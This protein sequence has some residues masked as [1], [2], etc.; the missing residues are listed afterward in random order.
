[1]NILIY[2]YDI[3]GI[4]ALSRVINEIS[5]LHNVFVFSRCIGQK[6]FEN[7]GIYSR[8]IEKVENIKE[9]LKIENIKI[10]LTATSHNDYMDKKL[11]NMSKELNIK[12]IVLL[13][14]WLNL[15]VRFNK[16]PLE[17]S[18]DD[19]FSIDVKPDYIFALNES[20]KGELIKLGFLEEHIIVVGHPKLYE[21]YKNR[22]K[23][24]SYTQRIVLF[25]EPIDEIYNSKHKY[26][27]DEYNVIEL[28]FQVLSSYKNIKFIIKVHPKQRLNIEL[29]KKY[30]EKWGVYNFEIIKKNLKLEPSDI[31]VGSFT[32]ALI[33][34]A[35]KGYKIIN[36]VPESL[37]K[38]SVLSKNG[39]IVPVYSEK[40]LK[41][42][43]LKG[44]V[45]KN[46]ESKLSFEKDPVKRIIKF[47]DNL[48]GKYE[49]ISN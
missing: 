39:F 30:S 43:I 36:I 24:V 6:Y 16:N 8:D 10:V 44:S 19:N 31:I 14:H 33:E 5:L 7:V 34:S 20:M 23:V 9:F 17:K 13:D 26:N 11:W 32:M 42:Y 12:S 3:G 22:I 38:Y 18:I 1:M 47:I 48:G 29:I 28:L 37:L 35:I 2:A 21:V 4:N 49:K 15:S 25:S 46:I 41:N 40:E 27:F 45:L